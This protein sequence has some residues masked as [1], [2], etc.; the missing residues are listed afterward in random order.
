MADFDP[1]GFRQIKSLP[2]FAPVR[3]KGEEIGIVTVHPEDGGTVEVY[4]QDRK[5]TEVFKLSD[6]GGTTDRAKAAARVWVRNYKPL[7]AV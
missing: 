2:P 5:H 4:M 7:G 6:H 3:H 1:Q